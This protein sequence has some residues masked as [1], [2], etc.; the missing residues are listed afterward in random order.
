MRFIRPAPPL[1]QQRDNGCGTTCLAMA[2][3]ALYQTPITQAQVDA[4]LKRPPWLGMLPGMLARAARRFNL[5]A[6]IVRNPSFDQIAQALAKDGLYLVLGAYRQQARYT[7]WQ[8][9]YNKAP[10]NWH[11]HLLYRI[12][13][14]KSDESGSDEPGEPGIN[15][16]EPYRG[17]AVNQECCIVFANDPHGVAITA[18]WQNYCEQFWRPRRLGLRKARYGVLLR[19][20]ICKEL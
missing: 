5:N 7:G 12:K 17:L 9:I 18:G 13:Q 19:R 6:Q 10:F 15:E 11:W 1:L 8:A 3:A 20:W 2:L 16:C 14:S 4:L